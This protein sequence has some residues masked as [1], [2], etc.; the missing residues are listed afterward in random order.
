[1]RRQRKYAHGFASQIAQAHAWRGEGAAA[2][3]WLERAWEQRDGGVARF[4]F[5][6][7]F[8]GLRDDPRFGRLAKRLGLP[9]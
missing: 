1:M 4:R 9:E 3:D 7:W 6:P 2:L 5:E 8:M